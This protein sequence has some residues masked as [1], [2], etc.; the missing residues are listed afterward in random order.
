MKGRPTQGLIIV[1][2]YVRIDDGLELD[3]HVIQRRADGACTDSV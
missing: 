3:S 1:Q 2:I